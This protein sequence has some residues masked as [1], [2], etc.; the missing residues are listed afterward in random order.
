MTDS[1]HEITLE[2]RVTLPQPD[3]NNI[4]VLTES[5]PNE[6]VL[7][8]HH[9][10]SP[11][12]DRCPD[13]ADEAASDDAELSA[14]EDADGESDEQLTLELEVLLGSVKSLPSPPPDDLPKESAA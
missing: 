10:D 12:L 2:R 14:P 4:T 11:W 5:L 3:V 8:W 1:Q 7:P 13:E 6:P 9:F